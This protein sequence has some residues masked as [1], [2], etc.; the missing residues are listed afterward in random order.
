MVSLWQNTWNRK[1]Q[2]ALADLRLVDQPLMNL[3]S[4]ETLMNLLAHLHEADLQ[5]RSSMNSLA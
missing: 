1:I 3:L 2:K 4:E 5:P